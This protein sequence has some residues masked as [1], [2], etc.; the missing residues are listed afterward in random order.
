MKVYLTKPPPAIKAQSIGVRSS[1]KKTG[2]SDEVTVLYNAPLN[3]A[4]PF[5]IISQE[6][7]RRNYSKPKSI[8]ERYYF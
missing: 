7:K 4:T 6:C 2:N 3:G 8:N 1:R 5:L